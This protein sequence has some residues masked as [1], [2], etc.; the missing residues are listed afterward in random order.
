MKWTLL[1]LFAALLG[2]TASRADETPAKKP[3]TATRPAAAAAR[4]L[5]GAPAATDVATTHQELKAVTVR[6]K[7]GNITLQTLCVNSKGQVLALVAPPRSFG[8][9]VKNAFSEVHVLDADG[10][11]LSYWKIGFHA[12]SINAGPDGTVYVAGDGKVAKYDPSGTALGE[13]E[14]PHIA[15]ALKDEKGMRKRAED[16][17]K[18]QKESFARSIKTYEDMKKKLEAKKA[19]DRTK[20]EETQLKQYEMI[21]KSFDQTKK[22]YDEMTVETVVGQIIGRLRVINAVA[23]S[24]K[25]LF[26]VCGESQGYGFA[27]WRMDLDLK[28]AQQIMNGVSGCCGQMDLQCCGSDFLL[29]ENTKHRFAKYSRD[30]KPLAQIGARGKETEA[31]TFGGCCNPMNVRCC[32]SGDIFTAESEGIVKRFSAKG[33]AQGIVAMTKLTGGCKNVAVASNADGSRVYLCGQPNSQVV[34]FAKKSEAK[35]DK[36]AE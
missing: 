13:T 21:L 23:A 14:L 35:A 25:D 31:G 8:A 2:S 22:Y 4:V 15:N 12:N 30:G 33:E 32:S 11:E 1:A 29:A 34:I 20:L 3:A 28:N 7:E 26:I 10:K 6:G 9:P 24:E 5:P 17:I 18:T 16:Q 27:V 19:E 36:K